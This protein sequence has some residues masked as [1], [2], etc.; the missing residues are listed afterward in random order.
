MIKGHSRDE[1]KAMT[2]QT[3]PERNLPARGL[4]DIQ[5]GD[6]GECFVAHTVLA[7]MSCHLRMAGMVD[8]HIALALDIINEQ[9]HHLQTLRVEHDISLVRVLT[10]AGDMSAT[11]LLPVVGDVVI[12]PTVDLETIL[13]TLREHRGS[14]TPVCLC[15]VDIDN[16]RVRLR[17]SRLKTALH[18]IIETRSIESRVDRIVCLLN[19]CIFPSLR[20][21]EPLN[22]ADAFFGLARK[23]AQL[24]NHA[25]S[26]LSLQKA[27]FYIRQ[28]A[29]TTDNEAN[30]GVSQGL[31]RKIGD[32]VDRLGAS[33]S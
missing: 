26:R 31:T 5:A 12:T 10:R 7:L 14:N 16:V 28:Y 33:A 25:L 17:T 27:K 15:E 21:I 4:A 29:E 23:F 9:S 20:P 22:M 1:R 8:L 11:L 6:A 3:P 19:Q 32:L 2:V 30:R 18:D 13:P 24:E